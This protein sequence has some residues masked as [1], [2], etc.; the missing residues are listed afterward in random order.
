MDSLILGMVLRTAYCLPGHSM[1]IPECGQM[2]NVMGYFPLERIPDTTGYASTVSL[3]FALLNRRSYIS[4]LV[5]LAHL[6]L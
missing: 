3:I 1:D 5:F 6:S 2:Y 4:A